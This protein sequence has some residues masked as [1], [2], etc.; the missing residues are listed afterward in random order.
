MYNQIY[1]CV[2]RIFSEYQCRFKTFKKNKHE[3]DNNNVFAAVITDFSK[4]FDCVNHEFLIARLNACG[5]NFPSLKFMPAYLKFRKQKT[6]VGFV[7]SVFLNILFGVPPGSVAGPF[8]QCLRLRYVF[9][10]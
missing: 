5:F 7:F 10:N 4:T 9:P 3:I 2:D 8:F 6:K 1:Y